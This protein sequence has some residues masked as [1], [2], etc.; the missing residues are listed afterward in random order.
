MSSRDRSFEIGRSTLVSP[1]PSRYAAGT[2]V[3]WRG[4]AMVA[5]GVRMFLIAIAVL[6]VGAV[7]FL[8]VTA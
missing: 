2:L 6:A 8:I 1:P 5:V 3:D 7:A 4:W